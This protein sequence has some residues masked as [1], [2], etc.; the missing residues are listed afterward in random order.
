MNMNVEVFIIILISGLAFGSF[1]NAFVWRVRKQEKSK[2]KKYSI[3]TGRSMCPDCGHKLSAIDLVPIFS[4]LFLRGRC[5]YCHRPISVQYPIIEAVTS[6][7]FVL[8]YIYWPYAFNHQGVTY[9]VI[10]LILLVNLIA[11]AVYDIK[12]MLLP[13][14]IL[15]PLY[16][17]V[18]IQILATL[19]FFNGSLH[20]LLNSLLGM[21]IGG[22]VFY[23]LFQVSD[24]K[25]IGGGDV[26]LGAL[27]G[28][29]LGGGINAIL[30]IFFASVIGS[31][32]SGVL[33]LLGKLDRKAVV[34]FG[35]FLVTSTI[36]LTLFGSSIVSWLNTIGLNV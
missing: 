35:P 5:R 7:L 33:I 24:G 31:V 8:S 16:A 4:W 10:W 19:I 9:F 11:L 26:K 12:W 17:L 22:G 15:Y 29:F 23:I 28:L 14:K 18:V 27:L 36:I 13:N 6:T 3:L 2:S 21:L 25:W 32:Y 1:V 34:P 30:L 20:Y